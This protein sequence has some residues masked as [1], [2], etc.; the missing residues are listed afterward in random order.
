MY[1]D[2]DP[3]LVADALSNVT[4]HPALQ[5]WRIEVIIAMRK[6]MDGITLGPN[7]YYRAVPAANVSRFIALIGHESW[8]AIQAALM[9]N[10]LLMEGVYGMD[11]IILGRNGGDAYRENIFELYAYAMGY[12]IAEFKNL[13]EDF[14]AGR[15]KKISDADKIRI[16]ARFRVY[17]AI[18]YLR[19]AHIPF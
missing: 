6:G 14:K 13:F 9:G 3:F 15:I 11:S 5:S 16:R 8:H 12:T 10:A 2:L 1:P 17:L 7:Q 19:R 18:E 4:M